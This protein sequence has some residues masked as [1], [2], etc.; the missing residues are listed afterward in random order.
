M[1][2]EGLSYSSSESCRFI[3]KEINSFKIYAVT[4]NIPYY[5][6]WNDMANINIANEL[7][8]IIRHHHFSLTKIQI[9][10]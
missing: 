3:K 9:I 7:N 5:F 8:G 10:S 4:D 1:K 6:F 2:S